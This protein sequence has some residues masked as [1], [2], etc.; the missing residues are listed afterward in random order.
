MPQATGWPVS[1]RTALPEET[2]GADA[3]ARALEMRDVPAMKHWVLTASRP[4]LEAVALWI[5]EE[6]WE[7]RGVLRPLV[8]TMFR[9]GVHVPEVLF[10]LVHQRS[11]LV[12]PLLRN[13]SLSSSQTSAA[14][15]EAFRR[16]LDPLTDAFDVRD[17][18][19]ALQELGS[20]PGFP[21]GFLEQLVTTVELLHAGG[22]TSRSFRLTA[23]GLAPIL[24]RL[25]SI[26]QRMLLRLARSPVLDPPETVALLG[27]FAPNDP[28]VWKE[29][30]KHASWPGR[31]EL[32]IAAIERGDLMDDLELREAVLT[33]AASDVI[34]AYLPSADLEAYGRLLARATEVDPEVVTMALQEGDLMLPEG[35]APQ[36]LVPLLTSDCTA[37]REVGFALLGE[38]H[39]KRRSD[40]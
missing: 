10:D 8:V 4:A 12:A 9:H 18:G 35:L 32:I 31:D 33:W 6:P 11:D 13:P 5:M 27:E 24:R 15:T 30:F 2:Q 25:P 29:T 34:L 36:R 23:A 38:L 40:P 22:E 19:N 14:C 7:A 39:G 17:I 21:T 26:S 16:M 37:V 28:V 3:L 1:D 20:G